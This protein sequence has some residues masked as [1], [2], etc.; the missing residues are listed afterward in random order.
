M[1]ESESAAFYRREIE[2]CQQYIS[3]VQAEATR[4]WEAPSKPE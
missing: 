1:I 4:V 3:L 2:K